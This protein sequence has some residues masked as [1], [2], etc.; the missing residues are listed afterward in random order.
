MIGNYFKIAWRNLWKHKTFSAIIV[1]GMAIAFAAA[2]L[3]S[4]TA[5]R[6]LSFDKFHGGRSRDRPYGRPEISAHVRGGCRNHRGN[7]RL[8]LASG[9]ALVVAVRPDSLVKFR[10]IGPWFR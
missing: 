1:F 8:D 10:K 7:D 3:L 6:E 2:L 9:H 4:L 5:Y